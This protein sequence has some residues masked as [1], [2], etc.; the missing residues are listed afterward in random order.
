VEHNRP[1][2]PLSVKMRKETN[3]H[4]LFGSGNYDEG[5]VLPQQIAQVVMMPIPYEE[6]DAGK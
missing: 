1:I 3:K 4:F 5:L 2:Q 6:T